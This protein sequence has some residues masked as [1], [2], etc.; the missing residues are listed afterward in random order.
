MLKIL[1]LKK[2]NPSLSYVFQ[3]SPGRL[4]QIL[5]DLQDSPK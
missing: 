5:N 1:W 3:F 2:E 4:D